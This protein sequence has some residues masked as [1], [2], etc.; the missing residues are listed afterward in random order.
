[1]G[2]DSGALGGA[3]IL[4]VLSRDQRAPAEVTASVRKGTWSRVGFT[5]LMALLASTVLSPVAALAWAAFMTAWELLLRPALEDKFA[6]PAAVRSPNAGFAWLTAIHFV[7][8]VSYTMFPVSVW[9]TGDPVGMV[10]A[11]AWIC[12]TANHL[13]VY[14]IGNR[15][16][17][18][19]CLGPLAL[20]ATLA[21]LTT[22]GFSIEAAAAAAALVALL[23]AAAI[24]GA[25]RLVL[26]D[27]MAK[28]LAA[29][30]AAEEENAAKSRFLADISHELRTPLNAVI[31]YAELLEEES[32]NSTIADDARKIQASAKQLLNVIEVV[33]DLSRL[34]SRAVELELELVDASAA[35]EHLREA[36]PALAAANN[37]RVL[38]ADARSLGEAQLDLGRLHQCLLHLIANASRFIRNGVIEVS[39]SRSADG[40]M[41]VFEIAATGDDVAPDQKR[42]VLEAFKQFDGD[43]PRSFES[44]GLGLSLVRRLARLM[45]GDVEW[46]DGSLLLLRVRGSA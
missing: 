44:G 9:T 11:T 23:L 18:A 12:G 3:K 28:N 16:M 39:A 30:R 20:C 40:K 27:G 46:R 43:D 42:R 25:D 32:P 29:R 10:L 26:L 4:E 21:P 38:I 15:W 14:F 13:L 8:G 22:D 31:G 41:L 19:A 2:N 36:V 1:M 35:L 5:W 17:L 45:G 37:N 34:E 33:I 24:F 6:L 7:G